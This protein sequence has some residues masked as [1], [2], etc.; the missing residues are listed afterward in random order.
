MAFTRKMLKA[1][2]IEDEKIEQIMDAHVEVTDALKADRDKYKADAD[3]LSTVQKELDDLKKDGGD[4]KAK[5]EKEHADFELYKSDVDQ[6]QTKAEKA[7]AYR[8]MLSEIGVHDKRI[9]AVMRLSESDIG[10]IQLDE[11][12]AI[13]D[14]DKVKEAAKKEWGDYIGTVTETGYHLSNPPTGSPGGTTMS[15]DDIF[16][17]KDPSE[18]QAAINANISLF[19]KGK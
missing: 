14:A 9:D 13:K 18:R 6:K 17:I 15:K 7:A 2:G 8:K 1:M 10:A 5:Y 11:S 16:K 4:W 3:A 12:G 19:Q